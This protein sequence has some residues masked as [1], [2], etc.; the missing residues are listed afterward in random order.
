MQTTI[1][2]GAASVREADRSLRADG[3]QV[4]VGKVAAAEFS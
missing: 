1:P 3:I 2:L 4:G